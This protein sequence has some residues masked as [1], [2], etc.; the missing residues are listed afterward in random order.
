MVRIVSQVVTLILPI[1]DPPST[2]SSQ[3]LIGL[4]STI[5]VFF[6]SVPYGIRDKLLFFFI[7]FILRVLLR[8][9]SLAS[10]GFALIFGPTW[11]MF[12][13]GLGLAGIGGLTAALCLVNRTD[14]VLIKADNLT[15]Y[16][17][18]FLLGCQ[19]VSGFSAQ[20]NKTSFWPPIATA[21]SPAENTSAIIA[22]AAPLSS[23]E[24]CHSGKPR[25]FS[26]FRGS[27]C[28]AN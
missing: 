20:R 26:A 23:G 16:R 21:Y 19:H 8:N 17:H 24:I 7:L 28:S 6:T 3:V 11:W 12:W 25:L 10:A 4:R 14:R 2:G 27:M 22:K 5:A 1:T 18:P 13:F 9:Q 15:C